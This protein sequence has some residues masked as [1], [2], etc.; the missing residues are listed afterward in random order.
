MPTPREPNLTDRLL[1]Y[2]VG[3]TP[4]RERALLESARPPGWVRLVFGFVHG[5]LVLAILIAIGR[6]WGWLPPVPR[7]WPVWSLVAILL[8]V[9]EFIRREVWRR[10]AKRAQLDREMGL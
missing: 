7:F 9:T 3:K 4:R 1:D 6:E 8:P 5:T 10:Y 2:G